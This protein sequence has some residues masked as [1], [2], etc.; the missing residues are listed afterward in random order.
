MPRAYHHGN[1]RKTIV[2]TALRILEEEGAEAM[3]VRRIANEIGVSHQAP[4]RH[5]KSKDDVLNALRAHGFLALA[6]AARDTRVLHPESARLQLEAAA[7]AYVNHADSSPALYKLMFGGTWTIDQLREEHR[8]CAGE[9]FR[10]LASIV[11]QA[12][13]PHSPQTIE[14]T[15]ILFATLHG[16][17]TLHSIGFLGQENPQLETLV[18]SACRS[19][20]RDWIDA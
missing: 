11:G 18:L 5:F 20:M 13:P 7:L 2:D 15:Q 6:E 1:L 19:L 9:A 17:V 12:P 8:N 4:Y 3:S 16:I 10:S 14:R